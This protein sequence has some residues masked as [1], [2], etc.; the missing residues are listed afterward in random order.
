M[1][2]FS[3]EIGFELKMLFE[4]NNVHGIIII[5]NPF[6]SEIFSN[7]YRQVERTVLK[8]NI[9][10]LTDTLYYRWNDTTRNEDIHN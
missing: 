8:R 5:I 3:Y 4:R 2:W 7:T 9:L 6:G 1:C 10:Q